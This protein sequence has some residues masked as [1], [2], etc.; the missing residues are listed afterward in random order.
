MTTTDVSLVAKESIVVEKLQKNM[1]AQVLCP[2][3][4]LVIVIV[5]TMV[6]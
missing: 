6:T 2:I 3:L 4:Y 1:P 5:I